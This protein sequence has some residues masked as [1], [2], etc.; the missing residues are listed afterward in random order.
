LAVSTRRQ[1]WPTA[2]E[3]TEARRRLD[4]AVAEIEHVHEHV[5]AVTP[6]FRHHEIRDVGEFLPLAAQTMTLMRSL[7]DEMAEQHRVWSSW[8][9]SPR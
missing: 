7:L 9:R 1:T 2:D 5:L 4:D 3:L 8:T 6:P